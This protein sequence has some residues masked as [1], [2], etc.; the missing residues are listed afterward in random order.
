MGLK[1]RLRWF[2]KKT[3]F[4]IEKEYSK[5]FGDDFVVLEELGVSIEQDINNGNF[6]VG[7]KWI[8]TLQPHFEHALD[9]SRY[10]YQVSFDYRDVW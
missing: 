5:D 8:G 1:I 9:L 6:D 10:D 2:D 4:L 7:A 3:E